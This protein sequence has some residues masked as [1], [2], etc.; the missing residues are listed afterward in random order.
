MI[1]YFCGVMFHVVCPLIPCPC[2]A[3]LQKSDIW[4]L[5]WAFCS[6]FLQVD[7]HAV[8]IFSWLSL[9]T[10]ISTYLLTVNF[11]CLLDAWRNHQVL[12]I[13]ESAT[14]FIYLFNINQ[15]WSFFLAFVFE[16]LMPWLLKWKQ[17]TQLMLKHASP[18]R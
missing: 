11:C 18:S 10:N 7:P 16:H 14:D 4:C 8:I 1:E 12:Y 17:I 6:H 15:W 5:L 13:V 2:H 9:S 3:V